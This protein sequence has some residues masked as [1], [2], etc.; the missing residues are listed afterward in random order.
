MPIEIEC[1]AHLTVKEFHDARL[2]CRILNNKPHDISWSGPDGDLGKTNIF[3]SI[4]YE[5]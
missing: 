2:E 4:Y 1:P 3:N 5:H